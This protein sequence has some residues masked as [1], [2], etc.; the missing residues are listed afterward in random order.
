[1]KNQDLVTVSGGVAV[2]GAVADF[3]KNNARVGAENLSSSMPQL[4]ITESNSENEGADGQLVPAGKFYYSPTKEDF[5]KLK[6]SIMTIS[7]GFWAMDNSKTPKPKFTQLVG[8]MILDT[9]QPFVMFVSGTRL[10]N[11][12]NFGKEI[13]PFTSNKQS[14]IPMF[15]F[16][17]VL[18]LEKVK[19][20]FGMNHVVS[21][22]LV[23]NDKNQLVLISDLELLSMIRNSVD[24]V[25]GMFESFIE[26]KEVDRYTGE[27]IGSRSMNE[28][29]EAL[30]E[31]VVDGPT[32][33]EAT[34]EDVSDD[35]PF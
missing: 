34:A 11:M 15:A 30:V 20:D 21:Y 4:K 32:E 22:K 13:K 10:Q 12:W 27:L 7:R 3:F 8:G 1:M 5:E 25:E 6:V 33:S 31:D 16:E 18:G 17:V 19:T 24:K 14:P 28:A 23:R 9:L 35:I 2:E 26:Q 29:K